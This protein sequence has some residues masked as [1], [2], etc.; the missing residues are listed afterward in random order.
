[1]SISLIQ[2]PGE[3]KPHDEYWGSRYFK[4]KLIMP[5][6]VFEINTEGSIQDWAA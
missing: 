4:E 1:M 6:Q 3:V 2:C 5:E